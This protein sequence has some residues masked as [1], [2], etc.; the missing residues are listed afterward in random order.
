MALQ[1]IYTGMSPAAKSLLKMKS[2]G[3]DS[4]AIQLIGSLI[5]SKLK[6]KVDF[7]PNLVGGVSHGSTSDKDDSE[8]SNPY[9][10]L[11]REEGGQNRRIT[12]VP[13]GTNNGLQVNGTFYS[14]LP[15][16]TEEMSV[17]ALLSTG[18]LH[19]TGNARNSISFGD[20]LLD[21]L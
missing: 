8:K 12:I 2:N 15:N 4:G 14:A 7:D 6:S 11:I 10:Q 20:Q 17:D 16:I 1:F 18:M 19:I 13:D 5:N 3:Q 21:P 9:L